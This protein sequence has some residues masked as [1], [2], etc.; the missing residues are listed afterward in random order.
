M[1]NVVGDIPNVRMARIRWPNCLRTCHSQHRCNMCARSDDDQAFPR[2]QKLPR[3]L[4]NSQEASY[5]AKIAV[6]RA[7]W[8]LGM[9]LAMSA[10]TRQKHPSPV[11]DGIAAFRLVTRF[12]HAARILRSETN[13][14]FSTSSPLRSVPREWVA[15]N[16]VYAVSISRIAFWALGPEIEPI[17]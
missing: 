2:A 4:K 7:Q 13:G 15:L 17:R 16:G 5:R 9:K 10:P 14:E 3:R 11:F 8:I 1:R 6:T 12:L